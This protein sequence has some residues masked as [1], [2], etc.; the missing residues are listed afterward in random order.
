MQRASLLERKGPVILALGPG[1]EGAALMAQ[2]E[3]L[4]LSSDRGLACVT[5]DD[6]GIL[7]PEAQAR[8]VEY[9]NHAWASGASVARVPGV[10]KAEAL[11]EYAESVDSP[12]LV[13]GCP[14]NRPARRDT[15][16][17]L[18]EARRGFAVIAVS[19]P[20]GIRGRRNGR[21]WGLGGSPAQCFA[22]LLMVAVVTLLGLALASYAG[23]WSAAILYL[24]AISM[25]ALRLDPGPVL[26][27]A[28]ASALA[29]DFLFIP[30]RFTLSVSRPE[31]ALMLALYFVVS[32]TAGF[33][34]SKLRASERLLRE[35]RDRVSRVN[36][37]AVS[38]AGAPSAR[39]ALS[40]GIAALRGAID[41]EAIAI[42][43]DGSGSLK[44]E[45]ESGW[46]ALDGSARAAADHSFREGAPAGRFTR[47]ESSSEWRFEALESPRGR[48]GVVGLRLARDA[49]WDDRTESCFK[50]YVSTIAIALSGPPRE[51]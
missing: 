38:L 2:G 12:A 48:L 51:S 18:M 13:V 25:G 11:A 30:P 10:D 32:L 24:A 9:C 14:A 44:R 35:E 34:T 50:A 45:P 7:R 33:A 42:L 20:E 8:L 28:L 4:A 6:G 22:A 36:A 21:R 23:Y 15:A 29:W 47:V 40:R 19:L 46:E 49:R 3:S 31:D 16:A 39:A 5:V 37:L 1:E 41:C 26:L 27:A 43:S 17:R